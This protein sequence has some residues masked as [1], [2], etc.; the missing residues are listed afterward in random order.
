MSKQ[1]TQRTHAGPRPGPQPVTRIR[2]AEGS[3]SAVRR[4][5]PVVS[6]RASDAAVKKMLGGR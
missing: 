5:P 2:S 1:N 4:L 6:E 3:A